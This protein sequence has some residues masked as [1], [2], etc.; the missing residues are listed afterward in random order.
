VLASVFLVAGVSKLA[1][2]AGSRDAITG[3][4]VPEA[5]A[6]PLAA[7]LPLVELACAIA[8]VP[9][10]SAWLGA[11]ATLALLIAF[12]VGI[13]AN[14][15]RGRT[16]DCHCFGQIHSEPIGWPTLAR[17]CILAALAA[18]VAVHGPNDAGLSV[19]AWTVQ[20]AA[21]EYAAIAAFVIL[22]TIAL[23]EGWVLVR[24]VPEVR[25]LG[26]RLAALEAGAKSMNGTVVT[27]IVS[28]ELDTAEVSPREAA[29]AFL[30]SS[31]EGETVTLESVRALGKPILLLFAS[32]GCGACATALA[33]ASRWQPEHR[34]KLTV[35]PIIE[36]PIQA[37]QDKANQLGLSN[38]LIRDSQ[39]AAV[40]GATTN[41]S[42]VLINV[43][44]TIGSRVVSG[45]DAIR[46]LF[47]ETAG[48]TPPETAS[49]LPP[50]APGAFMPSPVVDV[51]ADALPADVDLLMPLHQS[52][53]YRSISDH[54]A[55]P[56]LADSWQEDGLHYF[57]FELSE[58][59]RGEQGTEP[60]TAVFIVQPDPTEV[61]SAVIVSPN[62]GQ[63]PDII[64]LREPGELDRLQSIV[65]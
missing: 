63:D 58:P 46:D 50:V 26:T 16:P 55:S 8:L 57:V 15:A 45:P 4:G 36:G 64:D 18:L 14:M 5:Y 2:R 24:L 40:Y 54:L 11:V 17:N 1:D 35:V 30:L 39:V 41:P 22:A 53:E 65:A 3:F 43:D 28:E 52:K 32:A 51:A 25:R 13:I 60:A 61:V 9:V 62:S 29:P 34:D 19:T 12:I 42:A 21:A 23:T 31:V 6:S 47:Y 20:L 10:T 33:E 7:L 37:I 38:V 27:T 49:A 59:N 56:Q 48:V 44:G